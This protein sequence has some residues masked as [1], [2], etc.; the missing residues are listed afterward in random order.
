MLV[1]PVRALEQLKEALESDG[2]DDRQADGGPQ[3]VSA[4]DPVPEL[5]HVGRVDAEPCHFGRIG[6]DGHEV[7][8]H[9]VLAQGRRSAKPGRWQRWS[10]SPGS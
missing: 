8:C 4:A 5:E 3:A 7:L 10:W 6:G 1:H 9:R 2:E